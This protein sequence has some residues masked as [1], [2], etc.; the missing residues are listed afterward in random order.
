MAT[1]TA[2]E[3]VAEE[4]AAAPAEPVVAEAAATPVAEEA[5]AEPVAEALPTAADA[6]SPASP[7][8]ADLPSPAELAAAA[9]KPLESQA[10]APPATLRERSRMRRRVR[11][12]RAARE[13][14]LR[15]LGGLVYE[16]SRF[17]RRRDDLVK[18]RLES[19]AQA[20]AEMAALEA[21]LRTSTP[22]AE[23][24]QPGVGGECP[25]CRRIHGTSDRFCAHCGLDLRAESEARE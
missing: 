22:V 1:S 8:V 6:T 25:R 15:N 5:A 2:A 13:V 17:R 4:A 23:V 11:Y 12:L 3:P 19:L 24:R 20:D 9:A 10:P 21:A 18:R 16:L 7:A 14:E